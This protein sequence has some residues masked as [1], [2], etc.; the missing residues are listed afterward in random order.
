MKVTLSPSFE[1]TNE[2]AASSYGQPVLVRR[3][4]GEAFGPTDILK[5]YPSWG[6]MLARDAVKRMVAT[7]KP[8]KAE[9]AMVDSFCEFPGAAER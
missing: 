8:T 7:K 9:Q 1:L 2:H 3:A 5:P 6:F 4:T